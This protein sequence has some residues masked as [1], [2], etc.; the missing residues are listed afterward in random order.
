MKVNAVILPVTLI[1]LLLATGLF[2]SDV[3]LKREYDKA[4]KS[5]LYRS[6]EK[7]YVFAKYGF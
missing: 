3:L 4:D 1:L 2:A 7:I 5:N 6:D